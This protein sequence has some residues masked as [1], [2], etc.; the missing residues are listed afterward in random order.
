MT[1]QKKG[2]VIA[3]DGPDGVGKTTQVELLVKLLSDRGLSVHKT[4]SSGGTPI[5]EALRSVSLSDIPRP[6][7]TDFYISLAM[8]E[9]LGEDIQQ[10]KVGGQTVVIDR[11]P[12]A[13]VAYNGYGSDLPDK[14][15]TLAAC[16]AMINHWHIDILIVFTANQALLKERRQAR[17]TQDYFEKKDEAY[18]HR[19]QTGYLTG[20]QF[21][22]RHEKST[23]IVVIDAS[24]SI[25]N[26]HRQVMAAIE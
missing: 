11:S 19:V 7:K 1:T 20:L 16:Q 18:H 15:I 14:Q 12:L 22:Q 25:D 2:L 23:K 5:G 8:G 9:A 17:N 24:A 4:R 21:M 10:R 26:V 3:L 13:I 6:T